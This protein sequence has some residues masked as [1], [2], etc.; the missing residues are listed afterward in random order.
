[1]GNPLKALCS[2]ARI[3]ARR[4]RSVG[5][6]RRFL[7]ARF[8]LRDRAGHHSAFHL[9]RIGGGL[10]VHHLCGEGLS[11][12]S[13]GVDGEPLVPGG[14]LTDRSCATISVQVLVES[15]RLNGSLRRIADHGVLTI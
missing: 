15:R 7:P 12:R 4:P 6:P 8:G 14:F 11:C 5:W 13:S 2:C 3:A 1:M 9:R 10:G